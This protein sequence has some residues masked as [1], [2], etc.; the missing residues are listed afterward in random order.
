M[1]IVGANSIASVK[2]ITSCPLILLFC[3]DFNYT[4][5]VS[6]ILDNF[7]NISTALT[8]LRDC[9]T[10]IPLSP[11]SVLFAKLKRILVKDASSSDKSVIVISK[12]VSFHGN[13]RNKI[14]LEALHLRQCSKIFSELRGFYTCFEAVPFSCRA[15]PYSPF[16]KENI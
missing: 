13:S 10:L 7:I 15:K 8:E 2:R 16:C 6:V 4:C 5:T 11:L 12:W 14:I 9:F 1:I 3:W